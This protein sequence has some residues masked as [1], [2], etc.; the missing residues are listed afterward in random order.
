MQNF[1]IQIIKQ[2]RCIMQNIQY[3]MMLYQH[4][5]IKH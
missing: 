2:I 1:K 3:P 4:M 5:K